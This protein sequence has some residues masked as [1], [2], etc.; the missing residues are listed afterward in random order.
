LQRTFL[1]SLIVLPA[2]SW[3]LLKWRER[4][5]KRRKL[6]EEEMGRARFGEMR[7]GLGNAGFSGNEKEAM[8]DLSV[9]VGRSGGGV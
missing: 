7:N 5:V 3:G 2:L 6:E 9:G 8:R 4:V 1:Y